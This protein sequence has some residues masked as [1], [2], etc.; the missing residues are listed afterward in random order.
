MIPS[1]IEQLLRAYAAVTT[2]RTRAN[3]DA[4]AFD[5]PEEVGLERNP[6]HIIFGT[7]IHRFVGAPLARREMVIAMEEFLLAI[8]TFIIEPG[9]TIKTALAAMIQ[10]MEL[11]LTW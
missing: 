2:F 8:P 1:A 5:H 6:R 4:D 10:P 3:T 11:P 7:G 9:A